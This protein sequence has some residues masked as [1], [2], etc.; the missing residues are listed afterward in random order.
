MTDVGK[1]SD[2]G[3][4]RWDGAEW[5][6]NEGEEIAVAHSA[7]TFDT[8]PQMSTNDDIGD[9]MMEA[10]ERKEQ[11]DR[12]DQ[13]MQIM[14]I[15]ILIFAACTGFISQQVSSIEAE[16]SEYEASAELKLA[17]ARATESSENQLLI[18]EEI[19]LT[20]AQN[21]W[22]QI[23]G[24]ENELLQKLTDVEEAINKY[25]NPAVENEILSYLRLGYVVPSEYGILPLENCFVFGGIS[26]CEIQ[27]FSTVDGEFKIQIAYTPGDNE[28]LT[29]SFSELFSVVENGSLSSDELRSIET[30]Y[31]EIESAYLITLPVY[32]LYDESIFLQDPTQLFNTLGLVGDLQNTE[33]TLYDLTY[34]KSILS[35]D[36][37]RV[38]S[39]IGVHNNNWLFFTQMKNYHNLIAEDLWI[40]GDSDGYYE[41]KS[42]ADSYHLDAEK[43]VSNVNANNTILAGLRD[44]A[45]FLDIDIAGSESLVKTLEAKNSNVDQRIATLLPEMS[46]A[47]DQLFSADASVDKINSSL[48]SAKFLKSNLL[49]RS[50]A[51]QNGS[52]SEETGLFLSDEVQQNFNNLVHTTSEE[53]YESAEE[54]QKEAR[55]MQDK[56]SSVSS[57]VLFISVANM[58]LGIAGGFAMKKEKKRNALILLC[59]GGLAGVFGAIQIVPTL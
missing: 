22:I 37:N 39:D 18:R 10:L 49:S 36:I 16:A 32:G 29:Q 13:M 41:N 56:L 19:L 53:K 24:E 55:E 15:L 8:E 48:N 40:Q 27:G 52:V 11:E 20:E 51:Y 42:M 46:I 4:W 9:I 47:L 1:I 17:D 6:P 23:D 2:D 12:P 58:L 31:D 44:S 30:L 26:E 14:T 54:D 7:T 3:N 25:L 5:Q 50:A 38:T 33:S 34:N 45:T 28:L 59:V 21:L 43:A 57:S 35:D